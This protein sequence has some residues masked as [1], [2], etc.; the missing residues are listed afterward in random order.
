MARP[1][2]EQEMEETKRIMERL[3]KTPHKPHK[4]LKDL[5]PRERKPV[6]KKKPR[7]NDRG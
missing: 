1:R 3:V 4:P 6:E 5:L 2:K 7:R